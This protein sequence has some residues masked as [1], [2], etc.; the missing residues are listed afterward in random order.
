MGVG[1]KVI[2]GADVVG[3]AV[4]AGIDSQVPSSATRT[5]ISSPT[6]LQAQR[7][8]FEA[9]SSWQHVLKLGC[10]L[11][12]CAT[13]REY[14]NA[15]VAALLEFVGQLTRRGEQLFSKKRLKFNGADGPPRA[16]RR[17]SARDSAK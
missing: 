2:D 15:S 8:M 1:A 16:A 12:V 13:G 7:L 9:A 6:R 17:L 10:V 14:S 5:E 3:C 11:V 4:G